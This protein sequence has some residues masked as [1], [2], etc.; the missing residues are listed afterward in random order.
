MIGTV[1]ENDTITRVSAIKN[2]PI[3]FFELALLSAFVDHD[4]GNVISKAPRNEMPK[5]RKRAKKKRFTIQL[6]AIL[7]KAAGP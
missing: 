7:F 5:T 6:V 1:H 2:I 3:K 4:E